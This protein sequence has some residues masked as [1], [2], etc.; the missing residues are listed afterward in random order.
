M[1][2]FA[3]YRENIRYAGYSPPDN[4]GPETQGNRRH[5]NG[6][7]FAA[8]RRGTDQ[9]CGLAITNPAGDEPLNTHLPVIADPRRKG[10]EGAAVE[11]TLPPITHRPRSPTGLTVIDSHET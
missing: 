1:G 9:N 7:N 10:I 4:C 6:E 11:G 3:A 2:N 8:Y 5:I